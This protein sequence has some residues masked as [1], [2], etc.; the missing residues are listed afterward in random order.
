MQTTIFFS[1][2]LFPLHFQSLTGEQ[3]LILNLHSF[4]QQSFQ[5]NLIIKTL[6]KI[7]FDNNFFISFSDIILRMFLSEIRQIPVEK[8]LLIPFCAA[9]ITSHIKCIIE[10]S[11][12]PYFS[13][14]AVFI[15]LRLETKHD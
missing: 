6:C 14:E 10:S 12:I 1:F 3:H 5:P 13:I 9:S 15:F 4:I 2:V 7:Q 8:N 11:H